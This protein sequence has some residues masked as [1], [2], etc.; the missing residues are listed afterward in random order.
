MK[1]FTMAALPWLIMGVSIAVVFAVFNCIGQDLTKKKKTG[2]GFFIMS[3]AMY[4][5]ALVS[6]FA[7]VS[8]QSSTVTWA[9]LGSMML[10]FGATF[11]N[12]DK[13]AENNSEEQQESENE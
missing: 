10:C 1:D 13:K 5:I 11:Y 6:H 7:T 8:A 4:A 3:L 12:S 2:I 9:C